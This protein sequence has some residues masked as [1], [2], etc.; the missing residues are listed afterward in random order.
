MLFNVEV[1]SQDDYDAYLADSRAPATSPTSRSSAA[2]TPTRRP[3]S[4]TH[5]EEAASDRHRRPRRPPAA[6]ARK[7][8]GQQLVRVITTTDHKLIGNLYLSRRSRG[9]WSPA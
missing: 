3:A 1:V 9:S 2:T 5:E 6:T 7:P 8:L 4:T